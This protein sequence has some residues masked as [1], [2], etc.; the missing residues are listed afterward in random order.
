MERVKSLLAGGSQ[1]GTKGSSSK[2]N[3]KIGA[4]DDKRSYVEQEE[5]REPTLN[6]SSL[7]CIKFVVVGASG[8]GKTCLISRYVDSNYRPDT[9]STIGAN[10]VPKQIN[11]FGTKVKLSIWDLTGVDHFDQLG[12]MFYAGAQV[13]II[14]YDVTAIVGQSFSLCLCSWLLTLSFTV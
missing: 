3:T 5:R 1:K 9:P 10:Y 7:A 2:P 4:T 12:S 8:V 11:L 13:V 6:Q 14:V